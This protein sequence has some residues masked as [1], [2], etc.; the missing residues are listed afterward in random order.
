MME[1]Q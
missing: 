1:I